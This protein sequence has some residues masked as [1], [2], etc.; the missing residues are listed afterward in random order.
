[1]MDGFALCAATRADRI[2]DPETRDEF[3]RKSAQY[4]G[5]SY[6]DASPKAPVQN[7]TAL[8]PPRHT[9]PLRYA[10]HFDRGEDSERN[11]Q[12]P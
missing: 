5:L 7:D 10:Q 8:S 6:G 4:L 1:M 9:G 11:R 12:L 3:M 2:D